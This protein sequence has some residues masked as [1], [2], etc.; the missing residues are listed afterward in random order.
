[1]RSAPPLPAMRSGPSVPV[2]ASAALEPFTDF[3]VA[4]AVGASAATRVAARM[5]GIRVRMVG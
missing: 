4:M 5:A 3:A 2:R 1:M